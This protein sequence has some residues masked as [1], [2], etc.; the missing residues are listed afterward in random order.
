MY[1]LNGSHEKFLLLAFYLIFTVYYLFY[2]IYT[3]E[4]YMGILCDHISWEYIQF[5]RI[6]FVLSDSFLSTVLSEW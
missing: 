4:L 5:I 6:F 3:L 2:D 1:V